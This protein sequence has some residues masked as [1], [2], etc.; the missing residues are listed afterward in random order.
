[1]IKGYINISFRGKTISGVRIKMADEKT[2]A[3]ELQHWV[4]SIGKPTLADKI[5]LSALFL[6]WLAGTGYLFSCDL[7]WELRLL[8]W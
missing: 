1:M 2:S 8:R 3:A 5:V 4:D 7:V 6:A